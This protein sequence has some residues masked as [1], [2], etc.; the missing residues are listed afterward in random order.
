MP[1]TPDSVDSL[2]HARWI[3]PI[4]PAGVVLEAHSLAIQNGRIRDLLPRAEATAR[5]RAAETIEL[6]RHVL[7]PGL[8]NMHSHAAMSLLRGLADDMPLMQ[9]LQEH[10]WPAEGRHVSADFCRDGVQL[11]VAEMIKGGITC[12]ND[13]YF[14]P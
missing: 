5:Y 13:M 2:I 14:F 11:A 8:I 6:P 12:F 3:V 1:A 7:M 10:I 4:E 9:W